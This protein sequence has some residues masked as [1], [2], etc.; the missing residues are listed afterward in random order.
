MEQQQQRGTDPAEQLILG[1]LLDELNVHEREL[2][3]ERICREPAFFELVCAVEDDLLQGYLRGDLTAERQLR[4]EALYITNPTKR[5]RVDATRLLTEGLLDEAQRRRVR[6]PIAR[7]MSIKTWWPVGL[8]FAVLLLAFILWQ[9]RPT[10]HFSQTSSYAPIEPPSPALETSFQVLEPGLLRSGGGNQIELPETAQW[11]QFDLLR[12]N[13]TALAEYD[14][15][16]ATPEHPTMWQ[17]VV[18][19]RNDRLSVSIPAAV[20]KNADYTLSVVPR[21]RGQHLLPVATYYFRVLKQATR[22]DHF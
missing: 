7:V 6:K 15:V 22:S 21:S 16:L 19:H 17:G 14:A 13:S 4:F 18:V 20:L 11:V 1:Y 10:R 3:D 12:S 5:A 2:V 8:V 9:S